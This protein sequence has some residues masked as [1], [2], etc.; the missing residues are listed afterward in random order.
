M[1]DRRRTTIGLTLAVAMGLIALAVLWLWPS[2]KNPTLFALSMAWLCIQMTFMTPR[3][4]GAWSLSLRALH[5]KIRDEGYRTS[6]SAKI[7]GLLAITLS[8]YSIISSW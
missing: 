1:N 8:F 7:L 6:P 4:S 5:Q 3:I 2:Y